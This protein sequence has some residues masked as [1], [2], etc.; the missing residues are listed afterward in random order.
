MSSLNLGPEGLSL[1]QNLQS[2][3][4][5]S[6]SSKHT[7]LGV[8]ET[9]SAESH[10]GAFSRGNKGREYGGMDTEEEEEKEKNELTSPMSSQDMAMSTS[11]STDQSQQSSQQ[12]LYF[13]PTR[14]PPPSPG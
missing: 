12:S 2:V 5:D 4:A 13:P 6:G 8:Q 10:S 7:P 1:T 11:V 9:T 14:S 3:H